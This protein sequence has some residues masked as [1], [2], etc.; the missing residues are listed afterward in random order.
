[1]ASFAEWLA[2]KPTGM[3]QLLWSSAL[4]LF[5]YFIAVPMISGLIGLGIGFVTG[6]GV[7]AMVSR[8]RRR[9]YMRGK[10]FGE[11]L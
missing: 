9:R 5:G 2:G 11:K 1:L 4:H 3:N 6:Y 8:R 10:F 7:R